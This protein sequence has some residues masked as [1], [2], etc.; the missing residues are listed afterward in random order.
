[1]KRVVIIFSLLI[2]SFLFPQVDTSWVRIYNSPNPAY[3]RVFKTD[4]LGNI[5]VG[6]NVWRSE[7]KEDFLLL[8]YNANGSLIDSAF[9]N[10]PSA[11][12]SERITAMTLDASGNIYVTGWIGTET[13]F[14]TIKY[15]ANLDTIWTRRFA[16]DLFDYPSAIAVDNNGNV[17][18]TGM[19][20]RQGI[21]YDYLTIKY[22]PNG[23]SLWKRYYA[24]PDNAYDSASAVITDNAGNVYVSGYISYNA[25]EDFLTIKYKPNGETLWTRR[26]NRATGREDK[27]LLLSLDQRENLFVVG[28]TEAGNGFYDVG[29][30]KY[31]SNGETLWLRNYNRPGVNDDDLPNA[32]AIDQ[33]GNL[34]IVGYSWDGGDEDFLTLKYDANGN[35]MWDLYYNN[36]NLDIGVGLCLDNQGNLYVGGSSYDVASDLDFLFLK[37]GGDGTKH[38]VKRYVR[39]GVDELIGIGLD[40]SG[41]VSIVG[42]VSGGDIAVIKYREI[43]DVGVDSI[44]SPRGEVLPYSTVRPKARIVNYGGTNNRFACLFTIYRDGGV[45]YAE[46]LDTILLPLDTIE[47]TFPGLLFTIGDTYTAKCS[48][49]LTG[50]ENPEND[51]KVV[52]FIVEPPTPWGWVMKMAIDYGPSGKGI[53]QGGS[54]IPVLE[55]PDRIYAFKGN[56]TNEFL[57]YFINGD[58]WTMKCSIPYAP[59]QRKKVKGGGALT[60]D[61]TDTVVY[62]I[63][64]NN[65]LE[66]WKYFVNQDTW[67]LILRG[68]PLGPIAQKVKY[69]SGLAYVKQGQNRYIYFSKGSKTREFYRYHIQG[70]SWT[71]LP[72]IPLGESGKGCKA[73]S[74]IVK[75]GNYIY[76]LKSYYNEFFAFDYGEN[77]WYTKRPLPYYG[78]SGRK[79]TVKDGAAMAY[80]G[81]RKVIYT[82]KGG[83][84]DEF[85]GYFPEADTWIELPP[86]PI[87][88]SNKKVKS[89]GALA[90]AAGEVYAF[91]G[92]RTFEF[93]SFSWDTT[94]KSKENIMTEE[95][96]LSSASLNLNLTV[97]PNPN[98][99][100]FFVRYS[101]PEA[102]NLSFALYDASGRLVEEVSNI[103]GEQDFS[104]LPK[105][106]Y[107]LRLETTNKKGV[108]TVKVIIR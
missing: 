79:K 99:G 8:K 26:Y 101:M 85:W 4:N 106:V 80:D 7:T 86:I 84:T 62:A 20:Q 10:N 107:F 67:H 48:V 40:N 105:G 63:K 74:C 5:Y 2:F 96:P 66:F 89:G 25:S 3:A 100:R 32:I 44:L 6:G 43:N 45:L 35:C 13:D 98:S 42:N 61:R 70:D 14:L 104:H 16:G 60:Y 82:F 54:L 91:K 83:N 19:S 31:N 37:Y 87:F 72:D 75:A 30:I 88:P 55:G 76:A 34:H 27:A 15:N 103:S 59:D 23:D 18:V 93:W 36:D 92:N 56:N 29:I 64:G 17:L 53:K 73:G 21:N 52:T 24:G 38:W 102:G 65:T 108:A 49:L 22:S 68:L 39:N 58:S 78:H 57:C 50:D 9:F 77:I 11:N 69:G 95:N 1:M 97:F 94:S 81:T 28:Y 46:R 51:F 47:L 90:Y 33:A 71:T 41:R 12:D